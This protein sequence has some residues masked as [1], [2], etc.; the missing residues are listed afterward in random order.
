MGVMLTMIGG[1]VVLMLIGVGLNTLLKKGEE[2]EVNKQ[3]GGN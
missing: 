2:K 1:A 3:T